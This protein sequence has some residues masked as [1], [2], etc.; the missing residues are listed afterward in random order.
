MWEACNTPMLYSVL[1]CVAACCSVLHC[2]IVYCTLH[3]IYMWKARNT[4]AYIHHITCD[5]DVVTGQVD[6]CVCYVYVSDV[7]RC[8]W[9]YVNI[10][11]R[12]IKKR[13]YIRA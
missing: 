12:Y 5:G 6:V 2:V 10:L 13:H 8:T 11:K 7:C 3:E 9:M 4:H 1:Q